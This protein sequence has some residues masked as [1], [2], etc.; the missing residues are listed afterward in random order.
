[1]GKRAKKNGNDAVFTDTPIPA[2]ILHFILRIA[3]RVVTISILFYALR[4]A[5]RVALRTRGEHFLLLI[6]I[7][8]LFRAFRFVVRCGDMETWVEED[9]K[10]RRNLA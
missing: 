5:L 9:R 2:T 7:S 8:T 1:M 3:L 10:R 4:I 6:T